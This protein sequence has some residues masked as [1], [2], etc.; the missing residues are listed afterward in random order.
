MNWKQRFLVNYF[1]SKFFSGTR[2][3]RWKTLKNEHEKSD[4][5][6]ESMAF[7]IQNTQA[8]LQSTCTDLI[9]FNPHSGVRGLLP[10]KETSW[11]VIN[12]IEY[13]VTILMYIFMS[14]KTT[15]YCVLSFIS[16]IILQFET[17]I[18]INNAT[19]YK[20]GK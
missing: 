1:Y 8:Q 3:M 5:Q 7:A 17:P 10:S 12:G 19:I 4:A 9:H 16:S 18:A 11:Y 6:Q 20:V 13:S 2:K 14:C 15:Q